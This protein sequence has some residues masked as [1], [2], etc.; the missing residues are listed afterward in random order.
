VA[1]LCVSEGANWVVNVPSATSN[2]T[3]DAYPFFSVGPGVHCTVAIIMLA[4]S[5][6]LSHEEIIIPFFKFDKYFIVLCL[7]SHLYLAFT[8]VFVSNPFSISS[9]HQQHY[10]CT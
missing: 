6:L 7:G 1:E 10:P 8:A 4:I 5:F 2:V 9:A 3:L